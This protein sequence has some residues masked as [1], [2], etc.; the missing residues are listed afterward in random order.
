MFD[1]ISDKE[2]PSLLAIAHDVESSLIVAALAKRL[3]PPLVGLLMSME[4][5][6]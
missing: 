6:A 4:T 1:N 2:L 5:R 3:A